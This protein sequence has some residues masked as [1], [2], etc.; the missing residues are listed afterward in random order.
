MFRKIFRKIRKITKK[1]IGSLNFGFLINRKKKV[2]IL[3]FIKRIPNF[4]FG[5]FG[6]KKKNPSG[7]SYKRMERRKRF[8]VLGVS[9]VFLLVAGLAVA[10][11]IGSFSTG[12]IN[13]GLVGHWP[14]DSAHL[15]STTNR[16]DDISGHGN[17]GTN[18]G[19]SLT[20]DRYGQSNGAMS[21]NGTSNYIS[22]VSDDSLN[23]RTHDL[24]ASFWI[25]APLPI[26]GDGYTGIVW[27][28]YGYGSPDG[29]SWWIRQNAAGSRIEV[30]LSPNSGAQTL[31]TSIKDIL[32]DAWHHVVAIFD[33]DVGIKIYI[34]GAFDNSVSGS[35]GFANDQSGGNPLYIGKK[36]GGNYSYINGKIQELRVYNRALSEPEIE[37]LYETYKPKFSVGSGNKGLVGHWPLRPEGAGAEGTENLITE[38]SFA[39]WSTDSSGYSTKGTLTPQSDGSVL[40]EDVDSNT[41]LK[42]GTLPI[43]LN[44]NY[45]VSVNFK[46]L[47]GTPTFRWQIQGRNSSGGIVTS[48]WTQNLQNHVQD[49]DGWQ[50]L[51]YTF[52]FTN[53]LVTQVFLW[54]QDGADYTG[55]T[56]SYYLKE[57]QLEEKNHVTL[58]VD[59][60]RLDRTADSTPNSNHGEIYGAEIRNH[61]ASFN[62]SSDKIT[63]SN[64]LYGKTKFTMS[65]WI[66]KS[67]TGGQI[68]FGAVNGS[69][70][71]AEIVFYTNGNL[72][73]EVGATASVYGT[74]AVTNDLNWHH[75]TLVYDG[76]GATNADK[77]KLYF[78]G[79]ALSLSFAGTIAS[80]V[81]CASDFEI[82]HRYNGYSSGNIADVRVYDRALSAD[83]VLE[84]YQG[85]D[86][87][88]A[89]LD[90]PLSDK[91]GFKDISGNDNH[92]TNYGA[93]IIG[94]AGGFDGVD[95]YVDC[96]ADEHLNI[97]EAITI[98]VWAYMPTLQI[99][100]VRII[101][102]DSA[103]GLY[104]DK[105]SYPDTNAWTMAITDTDSSMHYL[106]FSLLPL[107]EWVHLIFTHDAITGK[108]IRY[109]NGNMLYSTTGSN[110]EIKSI[111][112]DITF[113]KYSSYYFDGQIS[114][115]RI[116]DRALSNGGVSV[117]QAAKGEIGALYA[118]G[119]SGSSVGTSTTNLNKGLVGQWDLKSKNEKVGDNFITSGYNGESTSGWY[120]PS[121]PTYGTFS[122]GA[123]SG[124][125]FTANV[126]K[127]IASS[128]YSAHR[129]WAA[130]GGQNEQFANGSNYR[131]QFKYR[132]SQ[133]LRLMNRD[134]SIQDFA[135]NTGDAILASV[136][137]SPTNITWGDAWILFR[138]SGD[139]GDYVEVDDIKIVR[140]KT[141]DSTPYGNHGTIYGATV[142]DDY[143]SFNGT[144][145][146][147]NCGNDDS[148]Q[149]SS[150]DSYTI[151]FWFYRNSVAHSWDVLVW[152]NLTGD[153]K[154]YL[155]LTSDKIWRW[156]DFAG[157][158]IS[159]NEWTFITYT[160]SADGA[161]YG[162]E[163]FYKNG[164][165]NTQR[166]GSIP[167]PEIN[168][169]LYISGEEAA[170][171]AVGSLNGRITNV[172]I[173]NR[174]LSG[175][176]VK[177]LYDKG[178]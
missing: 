81:T 144:S 12:D 140:I 29:N 52:S 128:T 31:C 112:S 83:E 60:T 173:Y 46:K 155:N 123:S 16:V 160:F 15:N 27:K 5:L 135:T 131:I 23:A 125:G 157:P 41:R 55:Y 148:L 145:D 111:I 19:A 4:I 92:G 174:V 57:P 84:L 37:K 9:V 70:E 11:V 108:D 176:E 137:Y 105:Y 114:D 154:I 168:S 3:G 120:S 136:D 93:D 113:G 171:G 22:M 161:N 124:S 109:V 167:S 118:K 61:G 116:Y 77:I 30:A 151:S 6:S 91:T 13:K 139:S 18:S 73:G 110:Y 98:S 100:P 119:R 152:N 165:F 63:A 51:S 53:P 106:G 158:T 35:S 71:R 8:A 48:Y 90:M 172:K 42:N 75:A 175:A 62:G 40:I 7:L 178:R 79:S 78:D 39:N 68:S 28:H 88:G 86:V 44:T 69:A 26:A 163:K 36:I 129:F 72:Y 87:A 25:K 166:I 56:H 133:T 32:D 64:M 170:A 132:S 126:L 20:T 169:S 10:G 159:F 80:S 54:F 14:L 164:S 147:V 49:I 89:V 177:L 82:G 95:D 2:G 115:V 76:A 34:D 141:A 104:R 153:R 99:T 67:A 85:A 143:T 45:T 1:K 43:S 146:Y 24:T 74:A 130:S 107:G 134:T 103:Y 33:R 66:K 65:G 59:G 38:T 127:Y 101:S 122:N 162:T 94:E 50:H 121:Q 117:G 149:F 21:F 150:T 17:H 102:K 156:D 97:T 47:S 142:G 58:F 138:F 96:G